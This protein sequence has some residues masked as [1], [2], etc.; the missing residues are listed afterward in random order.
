MAYPTAKINIHAVR[1]W[2]RNCPVCQKMRDVGIR[3][4]P[5][6]TLTLKKGEYRKTTGI[7]H[8]AVKED[9]NGNSVVLMIVEH[10]SHFPHAY[11]AKGYTAEEVARVLF[12]HIAVFGT[13]SEIASDPG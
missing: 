13:F 10:C 5:E 4:L 1:E 11:P 9:K 12:K 6:R 7:D 8:L 2:V 3:G